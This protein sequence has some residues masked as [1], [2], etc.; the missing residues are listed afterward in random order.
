MTMNYFFLAQLFAN[1]I[2]HELIF[3]TSDHSL[4]TFGLLKNSG[5][6]FRT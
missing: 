1:A 4:I 6:L 5:L 3:I 2:R